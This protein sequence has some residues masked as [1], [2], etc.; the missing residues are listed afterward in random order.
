MLFETLFDGDVQL[1]I[2]GAPAMVTAV[3]FGPMWF[4]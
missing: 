3:A 4:R 1:G 2:V